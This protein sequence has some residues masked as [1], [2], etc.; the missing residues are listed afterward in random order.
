MYGESS[1]RRILENRAKEKIIVFREFYI[2][3]IVARVM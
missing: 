2:S 3:S 1:D